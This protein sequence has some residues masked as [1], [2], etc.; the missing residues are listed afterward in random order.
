MAQI[1]LTQL[2]KDFMANDKEIKQKDVIDLLKGVGIE[3]KS[4]ASLDGEELDVFLTLLTLDNQIGNLKAYLSHE[5]KLISELPKPQKV[6]KPA[7]KP[8]EEPAP[9]PQPK[10]TAA[11][12]PAEAP[13]KPVREGQPKVA[14]PA[15]PVA[16]PEQRPAQASRKPVSQADL[17]RKMAEFRATQAKATEHEEELRRKM[18]AET[19]AKNPTVDL[20]NTPAAAQQRAKAESKSQQA[21]PQQKKEVKVLK[22]KAPVDRFSGFDSSALTKG[23]EKKKEQPQERER[24][25]TPTGPVHTGG[26]EAVVTSQKTRIV[27]TRTAS[28]DLSRYDERIDNAYSSAASDNSTRQK[29]KKQ[30]TRAQ[31][32]SAKEKERM[33]QEKIRKM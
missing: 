4:G 20:A 17:A 18:R 31:G 5:A 22:K 6:V 3:K 14:R 12:R 23:T 7:P 13:V 29:L 24:R 9:A 33:A 1:K 25:R 2:T 11:R 27:D 19:A 10:P 26:G 32:K 30:D 28:V 8:K 21:A 16:K 15:A